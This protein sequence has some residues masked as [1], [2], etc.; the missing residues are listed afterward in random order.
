MNMEVKQHIRF[1][2]SWASRC[3]LSSSNWPAIYSAIK[4]DLVLKANKPESF[5]GPIALPKGDEMKEPH[6]RK[7]LW[8]SKGLPCTQHVLR[9]GAPR[10]SLCFQVLALRL[11]AYL[12]T[13]PV[14]PGMIYRTSDCGPICEHL[15]QAGPAGG[16]LIPEVSWCTAFQQGWPL[17]SEVQSWAMRAQVVPTTM[18]S[19]LL[20][21]CTRP[22]G[23]R[24]PNKPVADEVVSGAPSLPSTSLC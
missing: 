15:R 18:P 16:Q 8:C 7:D 13:Y 9:K 20:Q 1:H 6:C 21:S 3:S 17:M 2:V 24:N 5:N 19:W 4:K 23:A 12:G 22:D 14:I 10:G 11:C